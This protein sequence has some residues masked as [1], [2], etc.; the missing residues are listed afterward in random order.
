[1]TNIYKIVLTGP[2]SSGK[3]QM[4]AA[5]A[6]FLGA[7]LVPEFA[8]YYLGALGRPYQRTD[9]KNIGRGQRLWEQ[10]FEAK[11]RADQWAL[12]GAAD[13]KQR[14]GVARPVLVLDTDWTV[15]QVWEHFVYARHEA[16]PPVWEWQKGYGAA[17]NGD[18]YLLCAP[19]FGWEPDPLREHPTLRDALFALYEDLLKRQHANCVILS[20]NHETRLQTAIHAISKQT[21]P[22]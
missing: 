18:L 16:G 11:T 7:S 17:E 1:M 3:T 13:E 10:W 19:D 9:L 6:A 14:H 21:P 15:L 2:E 12:K 22:Y 5:L 20:G 4:A 8:R